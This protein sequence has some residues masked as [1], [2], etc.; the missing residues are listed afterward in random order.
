MILIIFSVLILILILIFILI[1]VTNKKQIFIGGND[2]TKSRGLRNIGQ[3]CWLNS[4][5]QLLNSFPNFKDLLTK[6]V[7]NVDISRFMPEDNKLQY[8]TIIKCLKDIIDLM[9]IQNVSNPIFRDQNLR[10]RILENRAQIKRIKEIK[11]QE[12]KK[13]DEYSEEISQEMSADDLNSNI[14]LFHNFT[15]LPNF[16]N[17]KKE[18]FKTAKMDK[19]KWKKIFINQF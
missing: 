8:L 19:K 17:K 14:E 16:I 7:S 10:D 3:T 18:I 13:L 1:H 5:I 9:A 6:I 4:S 12:I 11:K 15:S 2:S